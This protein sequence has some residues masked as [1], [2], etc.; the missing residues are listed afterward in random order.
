M[1]AQPQPNE[2]NQAIER[3]L[4]R[5]LDVAKSEDK[6]AEVMIAGNLYRLVPVGT[7]TVAAE[8]V[9]A[10]KDTLRKHF[11]SVAPHRLPEDFA[12]LREEFERGVAEDA[13][14]RGQQ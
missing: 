6:P 13:R 4:A 9:R 8:D 7:M 10:A 5:R 3:E 11:G 1:G 2:M 14:T 12:A